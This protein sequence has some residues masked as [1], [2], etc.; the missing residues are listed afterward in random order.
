M[1]FDSYAT[2][3]LDKLVAFYSDN[4]EIKYNFEV[5][6]VTVPVMADM[7]NR[8]QRTMFGMPMKGLGAEAGEY[9]FF[10]RKNRLDTDA[11]AEIE[12][13]LSV[14]EK[15]Y[16]NLSRDHAFTFLSV[17]VIAEFVEAGSVAALKRHK[18]RKN[19]R[20]NGWVVARVAV[21]GQDGTVCCNKDG[22]DLKRMLQKVII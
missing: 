4:F 2:Q 21:F 19:Y 22:I 8:Q 15:E 6:D 9:I 20:E 1:D 12:T 3:A 14:A 16:V 7:H 5:G 13:I 17:V 11:I 18:L 10:L